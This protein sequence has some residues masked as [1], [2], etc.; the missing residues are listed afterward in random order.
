[1][2]QSG[3][4]TLCKQWGIDTLPWNTLPSLNNEVEWRELCG[5]EEQ[6]SLVV[7]SNTNG[8][9]KKKRKGGVCTYVMNVVNKRN[10]IHLDNYVT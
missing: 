4:I 2:D 8:V 1:M 3:V 7:S 5:C 9:D 6:A 10:R